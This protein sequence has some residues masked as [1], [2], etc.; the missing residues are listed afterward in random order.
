MKYQIFKYYYYLLFLSINLY[1]FGGDSNFSLFYFNISIFRNFFK[2][3]IIFKEY[4]DIMN[5]DFLFQYF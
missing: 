5:S 1:N 3:I 2:K 4:I